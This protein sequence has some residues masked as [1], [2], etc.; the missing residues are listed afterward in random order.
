M[1]NPR[2]TRTMLSLAMIVILVP[3]A[4]GSEPTLTIRT[5]DG[6]LATGPLVERPDDW[7]LRITST[8]GN[9]I[10][11]SGFAWT[12]VAELFLD[13]E[14]L[15]S[16]S[17]LDWAEKRSWPARPKPIGMKPR[18]APAA[19]PAPT[20][21]HLIGSRRVESLVI[22]AEPAQWNA[23]PLPDGLLVRIAPR[24][25]G[26]TLVPVRSELTLVLRGFRH[27]EFQRDSFRLEPKPVDLLTVT[28]VLTEADFAEGPA[29]VRLPFAPHRPDRD[30]R[31]EPTCLLTARLGVPTQGVFEAACPLMVRPWDPLVD[32]LPYY[33]GRTDPFR[34]WP[35]RAFGSAR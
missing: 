25:G 10:V 2:A 17:L 22:A 6:R 28:A 11:S 19:V 16:Q 14:A 7:G 31:I 21:P 8:G 30:F 34:L 5:R 18:L 29:V 24:D 15:T 26:G 9:V 4:F 13:G 12:E 27:H 32:R 23:D 35:E 1:L 33:E 20:A 3:L